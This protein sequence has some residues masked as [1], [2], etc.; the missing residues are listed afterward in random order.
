MKIILKQTVPKLGKSGQVVTVKDGYARNYLFPKGLATLAERGQVQALERR[1]E[2][3]AAKLSE[4]RNAADAMQE[5]INGMTVKIEGK[6]GRDHGKLFGAVTSQDIADAIKEQLK[7]ELEK[8][9]VVLHDPIK[10]LG[11][12]NV[13]IDLH[14]DVDATV[15][16][17]VFNPAFPEF[18]VIPDAPK[19]EEE[20]VA[21]VEEAAVEAEAVE[22]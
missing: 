12:T 16:V 9:Q 1:A 4:T 10:R 8:R 11:R 14:R 22:A 17:H 13:M 15:T 7:V 3:M 18:D 5:K 19:V 6:V 2:R 21:P 20:E